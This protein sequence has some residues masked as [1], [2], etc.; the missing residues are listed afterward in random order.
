[1]SS[2]TEPLLPT[3]P[4]KRT[5]YDRFLDYKEIDPERWKNINREASRRYYTKNKE[6]I[7]LK[8]KESRINKKNLPHLQGT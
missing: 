8:K 5:D 6:S 3:Q 7:L 1:M 2:L 4:P